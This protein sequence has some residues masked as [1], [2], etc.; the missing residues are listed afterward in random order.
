[1]LG[2]PTRTARHWG[3]FVLAVAVLGVGVGACSSPSVSSRATATSVAVSSSS[4]PKAPTTTSARAPTCSTAALQFSTASAGAEAGTSSYAF[5]ATNEGPS[6]CSLLGYPEVAFFGT[7]GAGGAGA[8]TRLPITAQ[9]IGPAP[10]V[11]TLAPKGTAQFRLSIADVP[12]NGAGCSD[13]ASVEITP[14]DNTASVSIPDSLQP[15]GPNV[16]ITAFGPP[17]S[18]EE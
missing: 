12:V 4:S 6:T 16:N 15:C 7:S 8:G 14:P 18:A 1:M 3:V 13:A 5:T 11:V 9:Q 2:K 17:G 10:T